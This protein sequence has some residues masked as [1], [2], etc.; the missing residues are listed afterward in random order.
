MAEGRAVQQAILSP[1]ALRDLREILL[2]SLKSFG[3]AAAAR[4]RALLIQALRDIEADPLRAGSRK[5]PEL[6]E[7][8]R[9][10]HLAFSRDTVQGQRVK[11]PRH[12]ILYR[13]SLLVWKSHVFCTTAVISDGICHPGAALSSRP[14]NH[15]AG[16]K[17]RIAS[18][19]FASSFVSSATISSTVLSKSARFTMPLCACV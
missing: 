18:T 14:L 13:T 1:A 16:A 8:A 5:R 9:T 11:E 6:A 2:W 12:F 7:G 4:Y 17:S 3:I 19:V 15:G 10:Y